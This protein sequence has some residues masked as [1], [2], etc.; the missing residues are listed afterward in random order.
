MRHEAERR[1]FVS[2]HRPGYSLRLS[3]IARPVASVSPITRTFRQ[4]RA[5]QGAGRC[6]PDGTV[7][8]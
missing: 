8:R 5:F 4:M 1:P 3:Q 7:R 6:D 2:G